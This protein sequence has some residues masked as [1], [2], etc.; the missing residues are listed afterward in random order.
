MSK[1]VLTIEETH[2]DVTEYLRFQLVELD[3]N[4][5]EERVVAKCTAEAQIFRTRDLENLTR[6]IEL[7]VNGLLARYQS[8]NAQLSIPESKL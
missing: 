2:E 8:E 1:L 3:Q 5:V 6:R 7:A 4:D